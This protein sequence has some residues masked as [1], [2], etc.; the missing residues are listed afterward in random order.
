MDKEYY[1]K[2]FRFL[3]IILLVTGL[4]FLLTYT[5]VYIYPFLIAILIA[6]LLH[7]IVN[8]MERYWKLNRAIATFI[9][10]LCFFSFLLSILFLIVK[11]LLK[12][13]TILIENLPEQLRNLKLFFSN[14]GQTYLVPL[15]EKLENTFPIIPSSD[16]WEL[17]QSIHFFIDE[18]GASSTFF[19]KNI[20]LTTSNVFSSLTYIGTITIF[21]LLAV[22]MM[23]KDFNHLKYHFRN[24]VP[25]K[26]IRKMKQ[27]GFHFKSSVFGFMKAQIIITFISSIIVLI[28]L[29]VFQVDNVLIITLTVLFV[30]FIPYAGIGFVFIPWIIYTF[31]T[32]Q[33]VLTIQ[34]AVLYTIII[35]VRQLIEPR[36]L[37]SSV[38]I[39]PLIT[40]MILFIGIQSLGIIGIILTPIV[41]IVI[42]AIYHAGIFHFI[43]YYIKHG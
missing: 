10:M 15:Y 35:I 11:R 20:V 22:F 17:H 7:P 29:S 19:L 25:N 26:M 4:F 16:E 6:F 23:T 41:L 14:I 33:Y 34:L 13:S 8:R 40:L 30:D 24:I 9:I 43:W 37:A 3:S 21:I 31:F 28:G 39:H 27:I 18:I 5:F 38:G 2:F 1:Y 12:E 36:I 42:S 32:D